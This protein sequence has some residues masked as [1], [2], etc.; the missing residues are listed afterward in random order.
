[1]RVL[2]FGKRKGKNVG[3]RLAG[4]KVRGGLMGK[5]TVAETSKAPGGRRWHLDLRFA[6]WVLSHLVYRNLTSFSGETSLSWDI[7]LSTMLI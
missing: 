7:D 5:E 1:M 2:K 6:N 4:T 3:A